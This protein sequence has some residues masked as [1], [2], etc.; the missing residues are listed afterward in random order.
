VALARVVLSKVNDGKSFV[1]AVLFLRELRSIDASSRSGPGRKFRVQLLTTDG[2]EEMDAVVWG[3]GF[4][5]QNHPVDGTVYIVH[6]CVLKQ[7]ACVRL[8]G[9]LLYEQ[10]GPLLRMKTSMRCT[11]HVYIVQVTHSNCNSCLQAIR[12]TLR[13]PCPLATTLPL[14]RP[15]PR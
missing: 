9:V 6:N 12:T 3:H 5:R 4:A 14:R 11:C 2:A 7:G 13:C 1:G 8:T 10:L 15:R